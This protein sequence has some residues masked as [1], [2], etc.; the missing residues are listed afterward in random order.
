M[1][2]NDISF[3]LG[4]ALPGASRYKSAKLAVFHTK[5]RSLA[6]KHHKEKEQL[7]LDAQ[8]KRESIRNSYAK[9]KLA[10]KADQAEERKNLSKKNSDQ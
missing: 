2:L 5:R 3:L 4:E 6:I 7:K 10:L 8:K 1:I 9:K